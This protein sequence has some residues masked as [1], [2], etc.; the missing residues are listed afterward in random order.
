V[1]DLRNLSV[2]DGNETIIDDLIG[3]ND[4]AP[5][6][7]IDRVHPMHS[8]MASPPKGRLLCARPGLVSDQAELGISQIVFQN[9]FRPDA[10]GGFLLRDLTPNT[11][12]DVTSCLL[13]KG[14]EAQTSIP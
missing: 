4:P 12:A 6:D 9:F 10:R 8:R 13:S 7:A 1:A 2:G 11:C 14:C 3:E 5:H